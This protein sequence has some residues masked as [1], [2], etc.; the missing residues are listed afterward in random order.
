MDKRVF[1]GKHCSSGC[2]FMSRGHGGSRNHEHKICTFNDSTQDLQD[3]PGAEMFNG[4]PYLRIKTCRE[5]EKGETMAEADNLKIWNQVKQPPVNSLKKIKGGRLSGMTDISP[6][7]RYQIMTEIFGPIGF[8]WTYRTIRLWCEN[9]AGGEICA[10]SDI[11][12]KVKVDGV[13]SEEIPGNGG[14]MLVAQEKNG[15]H[16][17]DEAYK[18]ATTDALS[19]AMKQLGVAADI[20]LGNFDG[21]KYLVPATP[22][23]KIEPPDPRIIEFTRMVREIS[24]ES[25]CAPSATLKEACGMETMKDITVKQLDEIEPKV[26]EAYKVF[27]AKHKKPFK[28]DCPEKMLPKSMADCDTCAKREGCPAHA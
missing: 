1:D 9:G 20:Y 18:M 23:K 25:M 3:D 12:L 16:T 2:P 8:G 22:E 17:S 4:V 10:F 11:A 21:S 15:P 27:Q 6:Q 13:W 19:V 7:W 5:T 24:A 26:R 14:S 28:I